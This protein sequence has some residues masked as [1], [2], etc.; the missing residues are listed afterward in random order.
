MNVE[1]YSA[2]QLRTL[3]RKRK[4][5]SMPE[6]KQALGSPVDMTVFRKL[7]ELSYRTSYSHGSRY[8]TLDEIVE[9]DEQGLW[10]HKGIWFSKHGTLLATLKHW[11]TCSEA[12]YFASDLQDGLQ[13]GV[14]ESLLKLVQQAQ[15]TREK[16]DGLY[17]YCSRVASARRSQL[18]SRHARGAGAAL[19]RRRGGLDEPGAEVQAAL[20]L[21]Y[22]LLDEKQR[23]LYA[24]LESLKQGRRG[25]QLVA[26]L[27]GLH[28]HTVAQGRR[29]LLTGD[30]VV[31][32]TRR[33]GG[34]RPPVKKKRRRWWAGS[35]S[36]SSTKPPET[37]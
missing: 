2:S 33:V 19:S 21:F 9:F 35:R 37:Q 32:R 18:A 13:V 16:I 29:E 4:V 30:T 12:G 14:K 31:D 25:D 20:V 22:S 17:L 26:S 34:G 11:I 27:L 5:A 7:R 3:F 15:V 8:Y 28:P 24:G 36:C 6:L 1:R 23:R 10:S